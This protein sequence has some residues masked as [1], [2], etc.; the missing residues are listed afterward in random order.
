M[1]T[2]TTATLEESTAILSE[3]HLLTLLKSKPTLTQLPAYLAARAIPY[4][5]IRYKSYKL[6]FEYKPRT[7]GV[8]EIHIACPKASIVASRVLS[9]ATIVWLFSNLPDSKAL[10]TS[11]P[12][13]KIAN[14]CRKVGGRELHR[15]GNTV[16]FIITADCYQQTT[17]TTD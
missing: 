13:G 6:L 2:V 1:F 4:N 14:M 11:C 10:I 5:I 12:E 7:T 3:P 15:V 9:I 8:Y 17:H 16:H